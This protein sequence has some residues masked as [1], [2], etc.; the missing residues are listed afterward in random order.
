M[1]S[2]LQAAIVLGLALVAAGQ[3]REPAVSAAWLA[4]KAWDDG[5]AIVSVFEGRVRRYGQW[6]PAEART[7]V[8]REYFDAEELTKRDR[9]DPALVPVLKANRLTS[10][11]TGT[12]PYRLMHSLFWDR[13]TGELVKA[14][15][16]SQEG[17]GLAFQRWDRRARALR[18][19]TYWEGEGA[20]ERALPMEGGAEFFEDELPFLGASLEDGRTI[21]VYP[22]LTAS[23]LRGWAGRKLVV[24]RDGTTCTLSTPDGAR[25]ARFEYD[26]TGALLRWSIEGREEFERKVKKRLFYWNHTG[27][28]DEDLLQ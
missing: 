14:T 9:E 6:R 13:R 4:S 16:S 23:N 11:L 19:D 21:T 28:G 8:I 7:Y 26:E 3:D 27:N 2:T 1:R 24:A 20:G 18:Y 10:F 22:T 5:A 15:G 12:Y 25:W 17:C